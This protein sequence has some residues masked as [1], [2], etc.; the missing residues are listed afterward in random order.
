MR[1]AVSQQ[2]NLR[3]GEKNGLKPVMRNK[4]RWE[5]EEALRD[6]KVWVDVDWI[7]PIQFSAFSR[8]YPKFQYIP[9]KPFTFLII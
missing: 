2:D 4:F 9:F 8:K 1:R 7:D 5:I 6:W 3:R